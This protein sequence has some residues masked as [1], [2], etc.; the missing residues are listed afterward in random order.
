MKYLIAV[1]MLI[2]LTSCTERKK[3]ASIYKEWDLPST[4]I[5]SNS[6]YWAVVS[7]PYL[8]VYRYRDNKEDL[9]TTCRRGDI[10]EV[11]E[12]HF[13]QDDEDI[14]LKVLYKEEQGWVSGSSLML[15]DNQEQAETAC[16]GL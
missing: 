12:R 5:F 11:L 7:D 4:P 8:K 2:L 1:F 13:G 16:A 15:F 6:S 3:E 9:V 14:W 10:L